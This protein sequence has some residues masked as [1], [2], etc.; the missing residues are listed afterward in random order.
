RA[1]ARAARNPVAPMA[2]NM[3][4]Q[5]ETGRSLVELHGDA[6]R[7]LDSLWRSQQAALTETPAH[8]VG[9][10]PAD[11]REFTLPQYA[12]DGSI[13]ALY[14][15]LS[16]TKRLVRLRDG[17]AEV[18]HDGIGLFGEL[19]FHVRGA[20]VV[21]SEYETSPRWGEESFLVIKSLD[22]D[23]R[24]VRRLTDRSRYFGPDGTYTDQVTLRATNLQ[25]DVF[26]TDIRERGVV[27][28]LLADPER[29]PGPETR[30]LVRG[31]V[32]GVNQY[33]ADVGGAD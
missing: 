32:A 11:Y 15:D 19:Q 5:H 24:R 3:S 33:L 31:Y 27:A 17:K 29:G 16:T 7:A 9:A 13:I 2:L 18:L 14:T 10:S 22:P 21:W 8:I 26:F 12:G 25:S 20:R 23:T 6:V 30:E 4:L 28:E 1:I